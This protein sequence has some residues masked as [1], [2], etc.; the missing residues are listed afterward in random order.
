MR[1]M[2]GKPRE[3]REE[4]DFYGT[5]IEEVENILRVENLKEPIL[6][7][8]CGTGNMQQALF[9]SG[10][11]NYI[12]TDLIDRDFGQPNL[13]FLSDDYP[14]TEG[15]ESIIINPPFKYAQEFV[16]KAIKIAKDKVIVLARIQFLEGI[17]RY[18]GIF[19]ENP[20]T[21]TYIY[22]DRIGCAKN[23]DF[24]NNGKGNSM[25]YAWYVWDKNSNEK[26]QLKWI[27][28]MGR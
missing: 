3:D 6:D 26:S 17:K 11:R 22:V 1:E 10:Y 24:I 12:A 9:N 16:E 2:M 28:K 27:R 20:P 8:C 4:H 7:P 25:V 19:K 23:N 5:P 21:R 15:I 13:D 14:Y 18:D